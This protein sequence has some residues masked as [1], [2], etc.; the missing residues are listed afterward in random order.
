MNSF[1]KYDGNIHPD[2]WIND[3]KIKYYNMWKNNYGEF[4]NTAKSLINSTIKLP[5]E[6]NDLEK[7]RDVLKKDISFT[8]FKNSNKRKLQSLKYKY[9]RDG[10]DT[11]KFFTEFRNLCYNS[12]TNDIEE[13]KKFFLRLLMIIP[14]F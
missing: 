8:V 12:E 6:I 9:E 10:G 1:L 13:Q 11:L 2:E 7:L 5:T 3:I 4:L 14:I